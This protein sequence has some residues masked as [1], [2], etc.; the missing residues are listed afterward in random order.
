[1]LARAENAR[2][3]RVRADLNTIEAALKL[4]RLDNFTYPAESD[5]LDALVNAPSSARS[6]RGPYMN[7]V[8][9]DPWDNQYQYR[10]PGTQGLEFDIYSFG[11][12]GT[13]GG[14]GNNADLG[15][16]DPN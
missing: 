12:D 1:M 14:E 9:V 2:L 3:D 10:F 7:S 6:W 4:Y 8:P 15:N 16:W 11:V 5:G 13:E